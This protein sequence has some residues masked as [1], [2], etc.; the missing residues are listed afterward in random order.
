MT[1]VSGRNGRG[2]AA[3]LREQPCANSLPPN[4]YDEEE[5]RAAALAHC[6]RC[7][8]RLDAGERVDW[9]LRNLPAQPLLTSSFGAQAAVSLHLL[10]QRKPDIPVVLIDTGY[11]FP[12]T[13]RFVDTLSQRLDL[14]LHVFRS[15]LSAA[16]QEARHGQRWESGLA[17]LEAYN[18]ENKVEPM[19]RAL[20]E[21]QAGTWFSGLR[22]AQSGCF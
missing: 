6:N 22:R 3:T 7:L 16:W 10:T 15:K 20:R 4:A 21:L 19:E 8:A 9:A 13:Y 18:Y 1:N 11:L 2:A 5:S 17:G 14:N 12:E